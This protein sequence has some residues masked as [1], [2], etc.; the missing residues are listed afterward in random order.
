MYYN[1]GHTCAHWEGRSALARTCFAIA[2]PVGDTWA[3]SPTFPPAV[4]SWGFA[5]RAHEAW[6]KQELSLSPRGAALSRLHPARGRFQEALGRRESLVASGR[7]GW[8]PVALGHQGDRASEVGRDQPEREAVLCKPPPLLG[9][10]RPRG[11]LGAA[12]REPENIPTRSFHFLLSHPRREPAEPAWRWQ[13][14]KQ[15]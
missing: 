7:S 6:Q 3:C 8:H 4:A 14:W 5:A 15:G 12:K 1:P 9:S 11:S 13:D 2:V 10:R